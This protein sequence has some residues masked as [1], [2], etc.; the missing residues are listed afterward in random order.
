MLPPPELGN[1]PDIDHIMRA[2]SITQGGRDA[3]SKFVIRDEY[4]PKLIPLVTVAEDLESLPDLHRLCN[5]MKSLILL[6]DNTIIETV[7]TDDIILGVVGA[8]EYDPEFPTHKANHRQYIADQSRYKE[9]VPI[10]DPIIRR[11]IRYTW[12]LQYLKDVVLARI[13][14]DPTFS[15]LNSLIFFNQVEIVNHIQSNGPFLKELFSVF[16]PRNADL[17]R[18]DDAVQFLHQCAG[19]AKNLQAP[20]RANLFANFIN[21]GLF[22]VIA[23]AIKHPNPAMRTTGVDLLVALLDHDPIMMRGYMLKAV[24]EKKTPLTD[25]LIDLLHAESDLGVKNQLADAIKVL[26]D[27]QIPLQDAMG[28]AGP[29]YFSKFRPN[30]L[31]DAFMQNHFDE[32]ARRLFLPLR[33]LENRTDPALKFFRTLV[34]LQDTFYQALMT[35]NNTFGLILDI[36]YETMPRDN[37]LNSACLEL[38][39]FIKR[40]NIKP[41]VLHIVEKYREK[42]KDITYV[43]TFQNLIL[44][45]EQMQGYGAEADSTL[46]SQEEEARKL[47][48]NGQRWQGVK[49][50]DAAEEEYFNTSDDEDEQENRV[51]GSVVV[52]AQNG[53]ASPVV[54]PLVDYPD[55]D[56]DE[57]AMDTKPEAD[58]LQA[59]QTPQEEDATVDISLETQTTPISL[60]I[61]APPERLSE[62]RRRE[63]EDDDELVKLTS[64]PKRRSSTSSSSGSAGLLR[65][66]RGMSIG[67]LST[68]EKGTTQNSSGGLGGTAPK[69]IAI[70]L[71]PVVKRATSETESSDSTSSHTSNEKENRVDGVK[72]DA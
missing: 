55:D 69:R 56:E 54:K 10:K 67:S 41:I 44:R 49:E 51:H 71:G 72:E 53:A 30:I 6:N 61:Q 8:L 15:V 45:Y 29:E 33:R 39:E 3:L 40:E 43:D 31:S 16:D 24:N 27:P 11:K 50:M 7:V 9:V 38:F 22:A 17:K 59:Q 58:E 26:L 23:F 52:N 34:S 4:I 32:S 21:H 25:T 20:A 64:G 35:H 63:E 42:I 70:N 66:K 36:V 1:L 48:A 28:R 68:A 13:L 5:I 19:I 62:K 2:A 65:R 46:F 47:Q 37:L 57:N 60:G 12:R 14:D 18:K